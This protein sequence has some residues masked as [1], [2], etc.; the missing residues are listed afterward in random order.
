[1]TEPNY[2]KVQG[3]PDMQ[4][5]LPVSEKQGHEKADPLQPPHGPEPSMGYGATPP[6]PPPY[7]PYPGPLGVGPDQVPGIHPMQTVY[8]TPAQPTNEPT[9][10]GYSIFTMLCCC[11][12]LGIAALIYSIQTRDANH[13]GNLP[14]AQKNSRMTR[15]LAHTAL[16]VG[17]CITIIYCILIWFV[18]ASVY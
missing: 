4:N 5:V 15:I 14:A 8:I 13:M 16:G 18:R 3:V 9:Y 7:Q 1:M 17:I 11:L 6:M 12:P 2:E 10:L